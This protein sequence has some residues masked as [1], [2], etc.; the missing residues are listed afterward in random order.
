MPTIC[1]HLLHFTAILLLLSLSITTLKLCRQLFFSVTTTSNILPRHSGH[2]IICVLLKSAAGLSS[3]NKSPAF[4][5]CSVN[6]LVKKIQR[7]NRH[8]F[9][10]I[11]SIKSFQFG[12]ASGL[13]LASR[14]ASRISLFDIM[15]STT[16]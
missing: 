1:P 15:K 5:D 14:I 12:T 8:I 4:F 16:S 7:Q 10:L 9:L 13:S 11:F 6:S 3:I 2:L